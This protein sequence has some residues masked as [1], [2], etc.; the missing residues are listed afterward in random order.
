MTIKQDIDLIVSELQYVLDR[1]QLFGEPISD[2][3]T[4]D[5]LRQIMADLTYAKYEVDELFREGYSQGYDDAK[6]ESKAEV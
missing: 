1:V 4:T 6:K 2:H 5:K 3:V